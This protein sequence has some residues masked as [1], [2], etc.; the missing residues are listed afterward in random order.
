MGSMYAFFINETGTIDILYVH[1][2]ALFHVYSCLFIFT[3]KTFNPC[4]GELGDLDGN[5]N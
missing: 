4:L 1:D 5:E 2:F 3:N